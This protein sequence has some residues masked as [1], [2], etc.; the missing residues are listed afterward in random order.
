MI[1]KDELERQKFERW[2]DKNSYNKQR[3]R[4][5]LYGASFCQIAWV[6][7]IARSKQEEK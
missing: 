4:M 5:G 7:W 2:L 1:D 3:D 6:G